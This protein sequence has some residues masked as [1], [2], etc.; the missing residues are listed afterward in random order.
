LALCLGAS[1]GV[2]G[3]FLGSYDVRVISEI[4]ELDERGSLLFQQCAAR[5][6][7]ICPRV[8][9]RLAMSAP[10]NCRIEYTLQKG[11]AHA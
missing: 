9:T 10:H 1:E 5:S 11:C 4:A 7:V 6:I 3:E 8:L 2:E